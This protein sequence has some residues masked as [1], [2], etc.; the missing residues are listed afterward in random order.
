M[1]FHEIW[2]LSIFRNSVAKIQVLLKS[3]KHNRYANF[4]W[5]PTYIYD[6]ISL[7]SS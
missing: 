5:R 7:I 1:D 4:T 2:Y 6:N 3:N